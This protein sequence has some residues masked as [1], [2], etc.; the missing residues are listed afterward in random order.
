MSALVPPTSERDPLVDADI[1]HQVRGRDDPGARSGEQ[2][3]D[4]PGRRVRRRHDAAV[5]ARNVQ[6]TGRADVA[7]PG[8]ERADV[9]ADAR[10]DVAVHHQH[11]GALVFADLRPDLARGGDV[12][13]SELAR[14]RPSW[15][16]RSCAGLACECRKMIASASAPCTTSSSAATI[17]PRW[18]SGLTHL[19]LAL[20]RSRTPRTQSLA[21]S[22]G[23]A[24]PS[25]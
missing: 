13:L 11:G 8:V 9:A 5:R 25:G 24:L 14:Q 16:P 15:R 2:R 22:G 10:R 17:N 3:G 6:R 23:S 20:M 19:P 18:S 7:L 1:A 12:E 4:R 21:T